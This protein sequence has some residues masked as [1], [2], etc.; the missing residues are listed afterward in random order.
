VRHR[1][2]RL[3]TIEVAS[4]VDQEA[5]TFVRR[6]LSVPGNTMLDRAAAQ[7]IGLGLEPNQPL[8][9]ADRCLS[10]SDFGFHNALRTED[11]QLKFIDFE[12]AGWDDP[13]KMVADFFCQ[14]ACPAPID[15]F[16]EFAALVAERTREPEQQLHRFRLLLPVYR[17]KWCCILLNDFHPAGGRRR[18]FAADGQED[19]RKSQ[20]LHK[21][22]TALRNMLCHAA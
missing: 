11:G 2:A 19:E 9:F 4:S 14:P 10:A 18:R 5:L 15:C 13:G 3:Q 16:E 17:L 8:P 6:D 20:Q 1:L 22:R 12:Y 7:A 21:A